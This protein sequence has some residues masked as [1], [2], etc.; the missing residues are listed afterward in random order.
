TAFLMGVGGIPHCTAMCGAAC[1]AVLRR[2]VP[3]LVLVGRGLGYATLGVAAVMSVSLLRGWSAEVAM[4]RPFW[5]MAQLAA[6]A[7][8]VYLLLKGDRKSTRLNSSHVK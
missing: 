1:V 5:T 6:L 4:L 8:G 2:P 7:L 3:P